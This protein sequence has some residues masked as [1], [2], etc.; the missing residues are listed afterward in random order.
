MNFLGRL[1]FG[2]EPDDV[3]LRQACHRSDMRQDRDKEYN[4]DESCDCGA[5]NP[6]AVR[7]KEKSWYEPV[8]QNP[9]CE[10]FDVLDIL[11]NSCYATLRELHISFIIPRVKNRGTSVFAGD[12]EEEIYFLAAFKMFY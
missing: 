5:E 8:D 11:G 4:L 3:A 6:E 7:N 12:D 9:E 2:G 1:G 10:W